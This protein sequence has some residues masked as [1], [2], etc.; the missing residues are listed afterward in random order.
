MV[1]ED[2]NRVWQ[3]LVQMRKGVQ[4]GKQLITKIQKGREKCFRPVYLHGEEF[5]PPPIELA[6]PA[7]ENVTFT[8]AGDEEDQFFNLEKG[9]ILKDDDHD[10]G[11]YDFLHSLLK[12]PKGYVN[13]TGVS[14]D[15]P[16]SKND[17]PVNILAELR[18]HI[19][20]EHSVF[21]LHAKCSG[22]AVEPH[23]SL[24]KTTRLTGSS[25]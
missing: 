20:H 2:I 22:R 18:D 11:L 21:Q 8:L 19:N 25:S 15:D 5:I 9:A 4:D 7:I 14:V 3:L 10:Q 6:G 1:A 17:T 13:I 23:P 24:T 16:E 12:W